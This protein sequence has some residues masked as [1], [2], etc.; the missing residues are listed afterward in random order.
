MKKTIALLSVALAMTACVNDDK[1]DWESDFADKTDS[2]TIRIAINYDGTCA[3]VNGDDNQFVNINGSDVIVKSDTKK[4]LEL[5]LSGSS[6]DGSLLIYSWKKLGIVLNGLRLKNVDGPAINNQCSKSFYVTTVAGTTNSLSDDAS[7]A[8]APTNDAG[9]I[10]DQKGTLFSE[11]QIYLRGTGILE[12]MANAKNG[13]ASDDYI[14][15]ESGTVKITVSETGSNG[16]KANDGFTI[17]DG[18]L[19]IDVKADGARGIRSESFTNI[20]GGVT[21]IETSGDC[22]IETLEDVADTTSCAGIKCDS[23]FTMTAGTLTITSSGDGG[24]GINCS[25]SI[26]VKGGE[27]KA[28]TTGENEVGKPKAIKSDKAIVISGGSFYASCIKS[29]ACDNGSDSEVPKERVTVVGTP[30]SET[31]NKRLVEI[32]F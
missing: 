12:I 25:D 16:I 26:L 13:I 17:L 2:D 27:L 6:E 7:Y 31:Y 3:T 19:N 21:S 15:L 32:I 9:E 30:K 20:F 5:T 24:K 11:G 18:T 14:V 22:V 8:T 23:L 4:F 29:W 28:T 10:I 1:Y